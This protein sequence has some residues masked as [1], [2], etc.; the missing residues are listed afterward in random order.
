[1]LTVLHPLKKTGRLISIQSSPL[2]NSLFH[3]EGRTK[4]INQGQ[5]LPIFVAR[6]SESSSLLQS[7]SS[8]HCEWQLVELKPLENC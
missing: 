6:Q 1:M 8:S 5:I 2:I 4:K 7:H 3:E